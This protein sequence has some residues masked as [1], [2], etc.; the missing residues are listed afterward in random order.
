MAWFKVDD[1]LH[2]HRKTRKVRRSHP[3]KK[4][5]VAPFGLW[6]L[7]GS[8]AGANGTSGFVPLEVLEE[9][10]DDHTALSKRL[11]EAGLWWPTV[12]EGEQGYGFH[13][14]EDRNPVTEVDSGRFGNHLRWHV[15]RKIT[16][17]DCTFCNPDPIGA[18]RGDDR[19]ESGTISPP[20]SSPV[21]T[22]PDPTNRTGDETS[23]ETFWTAY[24]R[25]I[26]KGQA[27]KAWAGA[28]KKA[29]PAHL[30]K[31]AGL[32]AAKVA[33]TEPRFI[34]HPATWLNGERW[35]DDDLTPARTTDDN[36][37]LILPPLPKGVF[38]Q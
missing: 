17:P 3:K 24:P 31:A 15:N 38:D 36:G 37:R 19:D 21:P 8:W 29:K 13:D 7:A 30:V 5:D 32:Y 1:G 27:R 25:K 11:V 18:N 23:F 26:G 34:A 28:V 2:D 4:R 12:E 10:D 20:E 35:D 22:R 6:V 9:W 16:N 33:Q 14:W